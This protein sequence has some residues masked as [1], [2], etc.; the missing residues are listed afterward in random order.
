MIS[1]PSSTHF[2]VISAIFCISPNS[3]VY[4]LTFP[5]ISLFPKFFLA[6]EMLTIESKLSTSLSILF[7][8]LYTFFICPQ[9]CTMLLLPS[10]LT[11]AII[12]FMYFTA[13]SSNSF[14]PSISPVPLG[15]DI[16]M[17]SAPASICFIANSVICFV[18]KVMYS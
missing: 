13:N 1:E 7:T 17:M 2:F 10:L 18:I 15:S 8:S 11:S 12:W 16:A 14:G 3:I 4:V 9:I 6:S 5:I